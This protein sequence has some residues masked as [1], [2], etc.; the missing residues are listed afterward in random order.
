[1]VGGSIPNHLIKFILRG[2]PGGA[3][4]WVGNLGVDASDAT[5][6]RGGTCGFLRQVKGMKD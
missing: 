3:S 5:K 6:Y 4:I 1:M 2:V